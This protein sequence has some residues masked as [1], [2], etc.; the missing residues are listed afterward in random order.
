MHDFN[1]RVLVAWEMGLGKTFGFLTYAMENKQWPAIVVCP[2]GLK[3]H[4]QKEAMEHYGVKS[5]IV[6]GEKAYSFYALGDKKL[7]IIN[8][9]I[10]KPWLTRLKSLNTK[11]IGLDEVQRIG[12]LNSKTNRL[13][14]LLCKDIPKIIGLSGTPFANHPWEMYP[15]LHMLCP[16]VEEF[17]SPFS[18]GTRYCE[19]S[20]SFG[21]WRFSGAKRLKE[22]HELLLKTCMLRRTMKE[23]EG[24]LPPIQRTIVPLEIEKRDEYEEA[25]VNFLGWLAKTDLARAQSAARAERYTR[26]SYLKQ[27]AAWL[28]LKAVAEHINSWLKETDSKILI[29][30]LHRNQTPIIPTL[31]NWYSDIAVQIHGGM[32]MVQRQEAEDRFRRDPDCRLLVAQIKSITGLNLPEA[33]IVGLVELPWTSSACQ[34]FIARAHR[35]TSTHPVNAYFFVAQNTIEEKLCEIIQ[36]KS[37]IMD[38]VLDGVDCQETSLTI[39][40]ELQLAMEKKAW[41]V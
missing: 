12:N 31:V 32:S 10:L 26:F 24:Q 8:Y 39:F 37:K 13:T 4:W 38:Q 18:F 40:D 22:L 28:K 25:E 29:G 27:L 23:V 16:E 14:Q 33:S 35:L 21:K 19:A 17:S 6:S 36:R 20:K 41:P 30:A 2:A 5:L 34:Q 3:L 11:L 15:I 7:I 9:E 1:G